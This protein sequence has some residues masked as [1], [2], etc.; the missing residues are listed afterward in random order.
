M[1]EDLLRQ[2]GQDVLPAGRADA[3]AAAVWS[4]DTA[5]DLTAL[6]GLLRIAP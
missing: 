5:P 6:V 3:I 2:Y 1:L 4:L